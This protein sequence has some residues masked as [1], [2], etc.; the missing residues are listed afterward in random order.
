VRRGRTSEIDKKAGA[1]RAVPGAEPW[2]V[3]RLPDHGFRIEGGD[4]AILVVPSGDGF[5]V[6]GIGE[7]ELFLGSSED[8]SG[9]RS[10]QAREAGGI[11]EVGWISRLPGDDGG[12]SASILL[13]DG[14]L[15]R[16]APRLDPRGSRLELR[17]W[18]GGIYWRVRAQRARFVL[19]PTVAGRCLECSEALL[20][21][22]VAEVLDAIE[23]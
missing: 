18:E 3:E 17:G 13:D 9:G 15:F 5:V 16:I 2:I 23:A 21:L 7:A 11:R 6:S 20:V 14:R 4:D 1:R 8:G 22:F 19:E 12:T 10:L